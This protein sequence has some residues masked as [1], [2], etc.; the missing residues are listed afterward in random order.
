M[1][2]Q[3]VME[4]R[5]SRERTVGRATG[6]VNRRMSL[7][8]LTQSLHDGE[9]DP[10]A[11]QLGL[12]PGSSVEAT[13]RQ[14]AGSLPVVDRARDWWV[15]FAGTSVIAL[16]LVSPQHGPRW[17]VD[18]R[19]PLHSFPGAA[20]DADRT[21]DELGIR[22]VHMFSDD[23]EGLAADLEL[24]Q[25]AGAGS[26]AARLLWQLRRESQL[27]LLEPQFAGR[28]QADLDHAEVVATS[29]LSAGF[30]LIA[31]TGSASAQSGGV[32]MM[33]HPAT[34]AGESRVLVRWFR[35]GLSRDP[36]SPTWAA[37]QLQMDQAVAELLRTFGYTVRPLWPG[38]PGG[39]ALV[40]GRPTVGS[41]LHVPP[42]PPQ[43]GQRSRRRP[44]DR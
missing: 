13:V 33:P 30:S 9:P 27:S 23:P 26:S 32:V 42:P 41:D 43:L 6:E 8:A 29:L 31:M 20:V 18:E 25:S 35:S 1:Q 44:G 5:R 16:A 10:T 37:L 28:P 38:P 3:I 17:L 7:W 14:A 22:L 19:L 39:P 4:C 12:P 21:G 24:P 36:F 40:T 15:V 11:V 34:P 2:M